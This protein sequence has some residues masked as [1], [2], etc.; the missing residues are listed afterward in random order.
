[1]L[2]SRRGIIYRRFAALQQTIR[3]GVPGTTVLDGEIV[4]MGEDG[5]TEFN[6]LLFRRGTPRFI[7]FDL[8]YRNGRDLRLVPLIER[9]RHLRQLVPADNSAVRFA[10]YVETDG[11]ELFRLVCER[12]LEGIVAKR[13][14]GLYMPEDR[15][16]LKIKNPEYS[17]AEGR[18]ELMR[19]KQPA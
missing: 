11:E 3:Q 14:D 19:R 8:L 16:W 18:H 17:Q 13:K 2:I 1:V 4:C 6:D 5:R 10:D 7:A 15:G 9:K 12:D